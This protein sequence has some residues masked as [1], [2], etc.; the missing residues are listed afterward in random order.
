VNIRRLVIVDDDP[1]YLR[2]MQRNFARADDELELALLSD[3]G[4]AI[5]YVGR[6]DADMVVMDVFMP[7]LNGIEA[8]RRLRAQSVDTVIV[9]T[10]SDMTGDLRQA[11]LDAG[12]SFVLAKPYNLATLSALCDP[13]ERRAALI[14]SH[15]ELARNLAA[16]LARSCSALLAPADVEALAR[17]GL[18]EAAARFD[19]ARPEPFTAYAARRI[20]GAVLDEVRR[21]STHTRATRTRLRAIARARDDLMRAGLGAGDDEVAAR[22]G[23][24]ASAVA[25]AHALTRITF[26]ML[27]VDAQGSDDDPAAAAEHAEILERLARAK[28]M[29]SPVEAAIIERCYTEDLT[30]RTIARKLGLELATAERVHARALAKLRRAIDPH[31][32]V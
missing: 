3:A 28:A 5:D 1:L 19:P 11:A 23:L 13:A 9:L 20:R 16:P 30:L 32:Q 22:L 15:L 2:A 24:P 25:D 8:C 29:L 4:T 14:A 17:L 26:V 27:D 21:L 31:Q 7:G 6:A 18:C 12:A 10:S